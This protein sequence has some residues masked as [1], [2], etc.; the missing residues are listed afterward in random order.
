MRCTDLAFSFALASAAHA[1]YLVIGTGES[2]SGVGTAFGPGS[3]VTYKA[4]GFSIR[5]RPYELQS[6]RLTLDLAGGTPEVSLWTG[7]GWPQLPVAVLSGG[8]P[9]GNGQYSY[10]PQQA[11]TIQ[12]GQT[13]WVT[14]REA[15]SSLG[16]FTWAGS[17]GPP[18][19][20]AVSAGYVQDGQGSPVYNGFSVWGGFDCY[21]NCDGSTAS[22]VL[23]IADFTCF[24]EQFAQGMSL[25]FNSTWQAYH[26][27]NCADGVIPCHHNCLEI[28]DFTCFLQTFA[29]GCP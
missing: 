14:V 13:Y 2:P 9:L 6:V 5:S 25:P 19:G 7:E 27:A 23:N 16:M 29:L 12:T 3:G 4:A 1:Q 24:L 8:E 11:V 15:P 26:Y 28:S 17:A 20:M 22:P 10:I 18:L 21:A